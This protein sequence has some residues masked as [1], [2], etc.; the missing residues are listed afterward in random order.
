MNG[1]SAQDNVRDASDILDASLNQVNFDGSHIYVV[2]GYPRSDIG[3]AELVAR[4]GLLLEQEFSRMISLF[5]G[6]FM[7][8]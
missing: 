3:K 2:M 5:I 8:I 4:L 1:I 6:D 7:A